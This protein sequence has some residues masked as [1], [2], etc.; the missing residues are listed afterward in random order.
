[1]KESVQESNDVIIQQIFDSFVVFRT[2]YQQYNAINH[3]YIRDS[4]KKL[5]ENRHLQMHLLQREDALIHAKRLARFFVDWEGFARQLER[6][7][8][9]NLVVYG[10]PGLF[11]L[12]FQA[13]ESLLLHNE[14]ALSAQQD[15]KE[16]IQPELTSD[17]EGSNREYLRGLDI[18][19]A[20][21]IGADYK[22]HSCTK[23]DDRGRLSYLDSIRRYILQYDYN[24]EEQPSLISYLERRNDDILKEKSFASREE[25]ELV[26]HRLS[27]LVD[28][29]TLEGR[30]KVLDYLIQQRPSSRPDMLVVIRHRQCGVLR[31]MVDKG[32]VKMEASASSNR[33]FTKQSPNLKCL[34]KGRIPSSIATASFLSF[35][36]VGKFIYSILQLN[37]HII[38]T[39]NSW[40]DLTISY[41]HLLILCA[42]SSFII[43]T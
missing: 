24:Q 32:L 31:F 2:C 14:Y 5:L 26:K 12:F 4:E 42:S 25:D 36:A 3:I 7:P 16:F 15:R 8:F 41:F 6:D 28:D 21:F 19:E 18:W 33:V 39:L 38:C 40:I 22:Y 11:E 43:N 13:D 20:C 29:R 9:T 27:L 34:E 17:L 10:H 35:V 1:L 23:K 30:L 37:E